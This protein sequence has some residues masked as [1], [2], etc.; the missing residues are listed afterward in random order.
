[1]ADRLTSNGTRRWWRSPAGT[2]IGLLAVFV[3]LAAALRTYAEHNAVDVGFARSPGFRGWI[4]AAALSTGI[5]IWTFERGLATLRRLPAGWRRR[6][7]WW[8]RHALAYL[9]V[10]TAVLTLLRLN[11]AA[12]SLPVPVKGFAGLTQALIVAGALAAA[13]WILMVWLAHERVRELAGHIDAIAPPRDGG[14]DGPGISVAVRSTMDAWR[15]IERCALALV[16]ST[17]A[18]MSG[19]LRTAL[20]DNNVVEKAVFPTSA[21]LAYGAFFAIVIAIA[22]VPL[23][24]TWRDQ[25]VSLVDHALGEPI[26]GVPDQM[27]LDTRSR[28]EARL[29]IDVPVLRRP[30]TALSVLA[31]FGTALLTAF[32]PS[33]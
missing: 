16:V 32:L 25:A 30:I 1:M 8:V 10:V 22:I 5:W 7:G 31:P 6:R 19:A 29:H 13:P 21:V 20:L 33:T 2:T 24:V 17:A 11:N 14:L 15:A 27:W 4:G 18:L 28:L 12:R 3:V 9:V 23:V 26:T